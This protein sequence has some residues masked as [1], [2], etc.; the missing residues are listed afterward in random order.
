MPTLIV[1]LVNQSTKKFYTLGLKHG[2]SSGSSCGGG[3]CSTCG[4]PL[5]A[6]YFLHLRQWL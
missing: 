5:I 4:R 2:R 6:R 3:I 1:Q